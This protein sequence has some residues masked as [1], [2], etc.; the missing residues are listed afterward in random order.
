MKKYVSFLKT[1]LLGG[2]IFLLPVIIITAV[3]GKAISIKQSGWNF[4]I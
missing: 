1:T 4:G 2:L 3:L